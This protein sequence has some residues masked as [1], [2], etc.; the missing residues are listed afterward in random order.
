MNKTIKKLT[1]T[2]VMTMLLSTLFMTN[3]AEAASAQTIA[4]QVSTLAGQSGA[5]CQVLTP[6]DM[7]LLSG[8]GWG[9][10]VALLDLGCVSGSAAAALKMTSPFV[11]AFCAGWAIGRYISR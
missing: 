2:L 3:S 1:S 11:G 10:L 9:L 6:G 5:T 8:S 4:P 7:A